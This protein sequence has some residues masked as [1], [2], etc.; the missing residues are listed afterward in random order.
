MW[1]IS[2]HSVCVY[3]CQSN[4]VMSIC[5]CIQNVIKS[6]HSVYVY[7]MSSSHVMSLCVYRKVVV[8]V[9]QIGKVSSY[10]DRYMGASAGVRATRWMLARCREKAAQT[11]ESQWAKMYWNMIR[12][13]PDFLNLR[14]IP[15]LASLATIQKTFLLEASP[16]GKMPFEY[17]KIAK[18]LTYFSKKL[19]KNF[20]FFQK[21]YQWQFFFNENFWQFFYIQ[22]AIF[23]RVRSQAGMSQIRWDCSKIRQICGF[24]KDYF[25]VH[26]GSARW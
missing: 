22:M 23:G 8:D 10:T 11:G 16:S 17:Y 19:L 2:C 25:S 14:Q 21:N 7:E 5:V 1:V 15:N 18:N 4:H 6:C 3:K 13:I 12:N 20:H 24:F 26:F 9:G